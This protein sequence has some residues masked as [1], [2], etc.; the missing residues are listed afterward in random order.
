[1]KTFLLHQNKNASLFQ[2]D[3]FAEMAKTSKNFYK[4][5]IL[6]RYE[7]V[8][9]FETGRNNFEYYCWSH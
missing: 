5:E 3:V 4:K 6:I 9:L 7:T 2:T 8:S 1:M